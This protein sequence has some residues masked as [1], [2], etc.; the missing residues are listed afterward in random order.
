MLVL[1]DDLKK[2][3]TEERLE[4]ERVGLTQEEYV[5]LQQEA[6]SNIAQTEAVLKTHIQPMCQKY[7]LFA[8]VIG[9]ELIQMIRKLDYTFRL[10][11]NIYM[12]GVDDP[13]RFKEDR[14]LLLQILKSDRDKPKVE[15]IDDLL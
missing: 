9:D 15:D 2:K 3:Y 11:D 12:E 1:D 7:N 13:K 6:E 4:L 10:A 8:G 14:L 5:K